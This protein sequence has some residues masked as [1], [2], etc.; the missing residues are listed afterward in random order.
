M[1]GLSGSFHDRA[2]F[3]SDLG[4]PEF[5]QPRKLELDSLDRRSQTRGPDP[6]EIRSAGE[7]PS[8]AVNLDRL[9]LCGRN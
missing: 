6:V 1:S 5:T 2:P 4:I 7:R 8:P 3:S 9:S